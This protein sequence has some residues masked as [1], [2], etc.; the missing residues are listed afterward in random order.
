MKIAYLILA[1]GA[2]EQLLRLVNLLPKDSPVLIH[3]DRRANPAT[4][5]RCVDLLAK[6]VTFV[7]RHTCRWGDFGIIQG[8]MSLIDGLVASGV[9]FDYAMLLSGADYPIKS[10]SEIA[11]YLA[12]HRGAELIESFSLMKHNRWSAQ[13]GI[14]K[15][16]GKVL[17]RHLRF[18]SRVLRIPG[19]RRMPAGMEPFGGS[20]WWTLSKG[21]ISYIARFVANTPKFVS[22]SKQ[23]F[24]PDESFIQTII[25]NSL[26]ASKVTGSDH[27]VII[28]DRPKPPYPATL[29]MDD[30]RMLLASDCLFARKFSASVDGEILDVLDDRNSAYQASSRIKEAL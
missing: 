30:L 29:T 7:P 10:N 18:R 26:F 17:C 16:P 2:P 21:A 14:F 27:R 6:R 12:R 8:T 4:F 1:H 28:W 22:F 19:F 24:I 25:S 20:Q 23:S 5:K 15:T 9:D 13:G 3:F 11:A